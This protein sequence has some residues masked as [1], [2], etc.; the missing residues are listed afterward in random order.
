MFI[1]YAYIG[2][3]SSL[4]SKIFEIFSKKYPGAIFDRL[5]PAFLHGIIK[6]GTGFLDEIDRFPVF[7]DKPHK[8]NEGCLH[9]II[10]DSSGFVKHFFCKTE[11][12]FYG[13]YGKNAA[14]YGPPTT[15]RGQALAYHLFYP[16]FCG[17]YRDVF[18][19]VYFACTFSVL[20]VYN[21]EG[22]FFYTI[23][24]GRETGTRRRGTRPLN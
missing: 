22:F 9:F 15:R 3:M 14:G 8:I 13:T 10:A 4:F 1:L 11:V 7:C 12:I 16:G 21:G 2:V 6:T 20:S 17:D 23:D 24:R 19:I 18:M 5:L